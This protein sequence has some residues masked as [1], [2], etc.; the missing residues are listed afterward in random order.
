MVSL[1]RLETLAGT[2]QS[3]VVLP[4]QYRGADARQ[5]VYEQVDVSLYSSTLSDWQAPTIG[6]VTGVAGDASVE[7]TVDVVDDTGICRV[8]VAYTDGKG[9][10]HSVDLANT[11]GDTWQG[12]LPLSGRLEY[13]AQV[14]DSAGN[15]AVDDNDGSYYQEGVDSYPVY[16]PVVLRSFGP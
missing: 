4:G 10:W 5:R 13:F 16:L 8:V 3:L 11:G 1:N 7:V 12:T 14:V 6:S 9:T 15:V 2:Q